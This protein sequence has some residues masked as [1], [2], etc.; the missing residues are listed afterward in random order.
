[1][2]RNRS[3]LK[4]FVI[5]KERFERHYTTVLEI[6]N[7]MWITLYFG[8]FYRFSANLYHFLIKTL[9]FLYDFFGVSLSRLAMMSAWK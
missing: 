9:S 2:V 3:K 5:S 4:S 8:S 1:L 7:G 6:R